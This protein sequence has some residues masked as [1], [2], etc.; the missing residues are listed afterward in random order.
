MQETENASWRH[1]L[2]G[3]AWRLHTILKD[4][5]YSISNISENRNFSNANWINNLFKLRYWLV[6]STDF[7]LRIRITMSSWEPPGL[8]IEHCFRELFLFPLKLVV[9]RKAIRASVSK[10]RKTW[11]DKLGK[12]SSYTSEHLNVW[13]NLDNHKKLTKDSQQATKIVIA[14][15]VKV[16]RIV[17]TQRIWLK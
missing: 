7:I 5:K 10:E 9:Q 4:H 14:I 8:A 3:M 12:E 15:S 1:R 6:S 11:L 17:L 2:W 13:Q 16:L